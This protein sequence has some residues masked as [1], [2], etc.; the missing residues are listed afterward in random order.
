M[1]EG[2][3]GTN[4]LAEIQGEL[5]VAEADVQTRQMMLAQALQTMETGPDRGQPPGALSVAVG[6]PDAA[7][8]THLSKAPSRT[9]MVTMLIMLGIYLMIS[10]TA[11]IL[12][13]QVSS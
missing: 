8:R 11:A 7:G 4:S 5:L 3:A 12:R 10:M 13:E 1:T 6:Q 9:R 2:S